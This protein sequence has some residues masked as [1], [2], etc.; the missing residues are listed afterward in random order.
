[1]LTDAHP[2]SWLRR[3][4]PP[5]RYHRFEQAHLIQDPSLA[6]LVQNLVLYD[7]IVVDSVLL[8]THPY[9][10]RAI[11]LFPG[12][13]FGVYLKLGIR[14]EIGSRVRS[15]TSWESE[16]RPLGE[17]KLKSEIFRPTAYETLPPNQAC[18]VSGAAWTGETSDGSVGKH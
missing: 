18:T 3:L 8:D 9:V 1:M 10:V 6:N 17:M 4:E 7:V 15:V 5:S 14:G 13:I 12:A 16:R 2:L 11:D